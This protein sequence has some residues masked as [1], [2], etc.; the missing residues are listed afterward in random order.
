MSHLAPLGTNSVAVWEEISPTAVAEDT[1]LCLNDEITALHTPKATCK[2]LYQ[3]S[4]GAWEL[5]VQGQA[6]TPKLDQGRRKTV[7]EGWCAFFG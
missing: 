3:F 4:S 1:F 7:L 5:M 2:A 6:Q